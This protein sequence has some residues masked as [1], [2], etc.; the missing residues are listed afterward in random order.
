MPRTLIHNDFNPRNVCLRPTH[1]GPRLC[2]Y[3]WELATY[4]I[5]QH[6]LVEF[7]LFVVG[8]EIEYDK[9]FAYMEAHRKAL[10][11]YA[12]TTIDQEQWRIGFNLGI[13]DLTVNRIA[14]YLM[15]HTFRHY[16][17]MQP[18]MRTLRHFIRIMR[19]L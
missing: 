1:D 18:V 12:Q 17:F 11:K 9:V 3:D 14:L 19:G 16:R 10:E 2:V 7:L 4:H 5:P 15:A 6:D 8:P 13:F